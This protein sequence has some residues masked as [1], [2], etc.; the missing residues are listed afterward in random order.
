MQEMTQ[1]YDE[2]GSLWAA[3][4]F[5]VAVLLSAFAIGL[6]GLLM[7]L[8]LSAETAAHSTGGPGL[9]F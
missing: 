4:L 2:S 9:L 1:S 3:A 6:Y 7:L 8:Q 5:Y